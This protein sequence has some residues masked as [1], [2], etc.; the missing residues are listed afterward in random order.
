MA[1]TADSTAAEVIAGHDLSGKRAVVTGGSGGIGLETAA[2]LAGAGAD[3]VLAVRDTAK[4][5]VARQ[6]II[7]RFPAAVVSMIELDLTDLANVNRAA[8]ALVDEG[9]PIDLLVN[10][11]GVMFPPLLRTADGFELQ[12]GTNHLGHFAFTAGVL[13]LLRAAG[14]QDGARVVNVSSAGHRMGGIDF[15]DPNFER[16]A[17]DKF[18]GYGQSKTA[19]IL[20]ARELDRRYANV[21]VHAFSLHPGMI[22]TDLARH[23]GADDFE[24]LAARARAN[25]ESESSGGF[26]GQGMPSFKTIPQGAATSVYACVT[27]DLTEHGGAYLSDCALME[28]CECAA[29]GEDAQ[30]LWGLSETLTRAVFAPAV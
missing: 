23:M 27:K 19:N 10:N 29:S 13:P 22:M 20:F 15:D 25:A 1:F 24:E 4:A 21:G 16:R 9:T 11:A 8:A 14:K 26:S 2:T 12:F 17:Y 7:D 18:A 30:R 6:T 28:P 5:T 3:V